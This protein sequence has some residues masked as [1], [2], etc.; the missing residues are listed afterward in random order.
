VESRQAADPFTASICAMM[1]LKSRERLS[2]RKGSRVLA[3][4]A[5]NNCCRFVRRVISADT[6]NLQDLR[7]TGS[8]KARNMK[9]HMRTSGGNWDNPT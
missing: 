3:I 2:R 5:A 6:N 7:G 1:W 8:A 9:I 4:R